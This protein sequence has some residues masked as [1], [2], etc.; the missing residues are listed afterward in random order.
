MLMVSC[1]ALALS[2]TGIVYKRGTCREDKRGLHVID[3]E[4]VNNTTKNFL[5]M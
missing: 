4:V 5:L 1:L 2:N 3:G